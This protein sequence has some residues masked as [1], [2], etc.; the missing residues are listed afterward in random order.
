M[1][2]NIQPNNFNTSNS[3]NYNFNNKQIKPY[4]TNMHIPQAKKLENNIQYINNQIQ[5]VS[6]AP[7]NFS[8]NTNKILLNENNIITENNYQNNNSN[9]NQNKISDFNQNNIQNLNQNNISN[10]NQNGINQLNQSLDN[11]YQ[12]LRNSF[13]NIND[14]KIIDNIN[15][16]QYDNINQTQ[17]LI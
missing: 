12:K 2:N 3:I 5:Q 13:N 16:N 4:Q 7:K 9:F 6:Y 10:Y 17:Y 8:K 15:Q 14:K 11:L 1:S